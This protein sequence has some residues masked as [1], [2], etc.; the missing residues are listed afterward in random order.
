MGMKS[1]GNKKY[2]VWVISTMLLLCVSF[3]LFASKTVYIDPYFHYHAPLEK[4]EYPIDNEIYQN[5]GILRNFEYDGIIT[6]TSMAE[7]FKTSEADEIFHAKYIKVPIAGAS[8]KR[9]NDSIQRAYDAGKDIKYVIRC[10]DY[11]RLAQDKDI[12]SRG[13]DFPTYLY[14][15]NPFDDVNYVLN[16]SILLEDTWNVI[17]YTESGGKTTSFDEYAN[18]NKYYTFGAESVLASY[19]LGEKWEGIRAL[20]EDDRK[21]ILENIRQNVTD[22]A[23]KHPETVFYLFFSP[24]SICY[25]DDQNNKGYIDWS[26]DCERVAIEEILKHSN[27]KLYS[28]NDNFKL[29]CDLD[30]Y[31]DQAHYGEWVNSWILEW[32]KED[33]YLLTEENYQEYIETIREFYNS[34]DYSTLR[35]QE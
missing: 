22:L 35:E 14:N 33:K 3:I 30:N 23:D 16:K 12:D 1:E 17:K 11:N 26:I 2:I 13:A 31:K 18:W 20:S 29:I 28:F 10:L 24:Y 21:M 6:G 5:D 32:M 9:I 8:F 7:N 15:D 34:Y 25:W 19:T 27:I 4:Y